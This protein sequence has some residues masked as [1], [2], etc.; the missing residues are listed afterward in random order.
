MELYI[1][2]LIGV[3]NNEKRQYSR[4]FPVLY[5]CFFMLSFL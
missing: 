5:R 3:S 1:G 2:I 4:R